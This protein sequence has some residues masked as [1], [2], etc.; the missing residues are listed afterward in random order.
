VGAEHTSKLNVGY[1]FQMCVL[2]FTFPKPSNILGFGICHKP[3]EGQRPWRVRQVVPVGLARVRM[4]RTASAKVT[5]RDIAQ[6]SLI[7]ATLPILLY[8][9][10]ATYVY[11][12]GPFYDYVVVCLTLSFSCIFV[13]VSVA[14]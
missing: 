8:L 5:N 10:R 4:V 2:P 6:Y 7:S 11:A 14:L 9:A 3:L 12:L 13:R 1:V